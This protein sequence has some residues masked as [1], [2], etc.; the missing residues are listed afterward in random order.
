[1]ESGEEAACPSPTHWPAS[2]DQGC[3]GSTPPRSRSAGGSERAVGATHRILE[4]LIVFSVIGPCPPFFFCNGT[5][6][7]SGAANRG[8]AHAVGFTLRVLGSFHSIVLKGVG[9]TAEGSLNSSLWPDCR[10]LQASHAPNKTPSFLT[11][12]PRGLP[13]G[14]RGP[15]PIPLINACGGGGHGLGIPQ[16]WQLETKAPS[17]GKRA[18]L[19]AGCRP[20]LRG[21][22][23][24]EGYGALEPLCGRIPAPRAAPPPGAAA[25][26][27]SPAVAPDWPAMTS[28]YFK[29]HL[30]V[31]GGAEGV[32]SG[33]WVMQTETDGGRGNSGSLNV[34]HLH[35]CPR[36]LT[37]MPPSDL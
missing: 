8:P 21:G 29:A 26:H 34:R 14:A 27:M 5:T 16:D 24:S 36:Y 23:Q 1:M 30:Q 37:Q 32:G 15:L 3:S 17:P 11:S 12:C 20:L 9:A 18:D 6:L 28:P 31:E 19:A 13:L 4:F 2:P 33:I 10:A 7:R 25:C 35:T 22:G